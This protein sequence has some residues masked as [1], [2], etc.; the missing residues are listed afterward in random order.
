MRLEPEPE[1]VRRGLD[2]VEMGQAL[3]V[4]FRLRGPFGLSESLPRGSFVHGV[5]GEFPTF[6]LGGTPRELQITAWC[7]GP[8][9]A[10][11]GELDAPSIVQAATRSLAA[12]FDVPVEAAVAQVLGAHVHSF[13]AD[14][15]SR[16]AYPYALAGK[17]AFGAFD[18]VEGTLFFAGDYTV[19][20][21]LGTVGI[22][23]QSGVA[24]AREIID[25]LC[26]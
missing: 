25:T 26:G 12:A 13:G 10:R 16:G 9:A 6:W 17:N 2:S 3:R 1:A 15:F 24:A 8:R 20:E 5:A 4:V 19:P 21:E 22:A 7:G 18:S 14:P 11:L 23:V